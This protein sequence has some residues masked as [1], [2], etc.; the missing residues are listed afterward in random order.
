MVAVA[1]ARA[2]DAAPAAA[3]ASSNS[4]DDADQAPRARGLDLDARIAKLRDTL[5]ITSA[6]DGK[7][8]SVADAIRDGET[9]IRAALKERKAHYPA[10]TATANIESYQKVTVA[11]ADAEAKLL[12]AFEPLYETMPDSQKKIADAAVS[13][14]LQ[15]H[16]RKPS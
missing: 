8:Q 3:S 2:A 15:P 12:S 4:A 16:R 6:E 1:P 10:M 9:E 7:W 5:Q 14:Y 11:H 13:D